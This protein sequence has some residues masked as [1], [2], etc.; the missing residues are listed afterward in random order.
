MLHI[1]H[2]KQLVYA[3]VSVQPDETTQNPSETNKFMRQLERGQTGVSAGLSLRFGPERLKELLALANKSN[4]AVSELCRILI[5]SALTSLHAPDGAPTPTALLRLR[6]RLAEAPLPAAPAG[7]SAQDS[8]AMEQRIVARLMAA[9]QA[10][11]AAAAAV[12]TPTTTT[13]QPRKQKPPGGK[14]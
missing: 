8:D 2:R 5:E 6:Q 11:A 10:A 1:S 12:P 9:M 13:Q 4:L 7:L 3:C 14:S